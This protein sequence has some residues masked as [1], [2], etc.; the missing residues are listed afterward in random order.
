M[1]RRRAVL[2]AKA[3]VA[4]TVALI[5]GELLS[6]ASF[7]LAQ[8]IF[9]LAQAILSGHHLGIPLSRPGA[10]GAVLAEGILLFVC[11]VMGLGLGA[12]IRP[13]AG[14]AAA[15]FGLIYLPAIVGLLPTPWNERISRF[16]LF[17]AAHQAVALHP[18]TDLFSP[19]LSILVLIAW[20][21]AALLTAALLITRRDA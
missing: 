17:Y 21:A 8:A 1:P 9:F 5:A 10:P 14:A 15:L 16:T 20:P 18:Q 19:A 7:F 6:F 4:G 11:A 12:I 2:V 13:T 3:A